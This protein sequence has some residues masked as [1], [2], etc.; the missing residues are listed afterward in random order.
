MSI[1]PLVISSLQKA[2]QLGWMPSWFLPSNTSSPGAILEPGGGAAFP[3]VYSVVVLEVRG[4]PGVRRR[5]T[6]AQ[7]F[8]ARPRASTRTRTA[9][10][11]SRTACG[12]RSIGAT[13]EQAFAKMTE[14][15][16]ESFMKALMSISD[17][18]APFM[19]EGTDGRHDRRRQARRLERVR[20]RSTT[21]RATPLPRP[22][23][24]P[25]ARSA[26]LNTGRGGPRERIAPASSCGG[27][28]AAAA[29]SP[30]AGVG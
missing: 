4:E 25:Q 18:Q 21:A 1:T 7:T 5:A 13:L 2:Q 26:D 11:R 24:D 23:V 6:R 16:R 17:F 10:P 27:G 14:P 19:L 12:A 30:R 28:T 8:L 3:G 9:S 29:S 20:C 22:S 15:T